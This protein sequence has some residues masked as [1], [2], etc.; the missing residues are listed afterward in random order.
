M[1][2]IHVRT[3]EVTQRAFDV[4]IYF[5]E[6]Q[7]KKFLLA[8]S[9]FVGISA[10]HAGSW[11]APVL[12]ALTGYG[13]SSVWGGS[14]PTSGGE[15]RRD[16]ALTQGEVYEAIVVQVRDVKLQSTD[17]AR[18]VGAATGGAIGGIAGSKLGGGSG[19]VVTGILGAV[20][21]AGV[22]QATGEAISE[23]KAGE[24]VVRGNDGKMTYIVQEDGMQFR[25][26]ERVL[27]MKTSSGWN[28]STRVAR[29][30]AM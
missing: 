8:V 20:I 26:G 19:K 7:M 10:A 25:P 23:R 1:L 21:G 29:M 28:S 2:Y 15:Y 17:Y 14:N 6:H 18:N 22:G 4:L 27:L 30:T 13:A 12:G 11:E 9:L 3:I 16:S 5:M 24:I